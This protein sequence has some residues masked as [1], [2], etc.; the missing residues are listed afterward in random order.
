MDITYELTRDLFEKQRVVDLFLL[1]HPEDDRKLN[2]YFQNGYARHISNVYDS[3]IYKLPY[4]PA[5]LRGSYRLMLI[6]TGV[7]TMGLAA[8]HPLLA[9]VTVYDWYLLLRGLQVLGQTCDEL[10]LDKSKRHIM[11]NKLNVLGY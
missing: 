4:S 1:E 11:L 2:K 6:S 3:L 8:V 10:V 7:V 9:V 5:D